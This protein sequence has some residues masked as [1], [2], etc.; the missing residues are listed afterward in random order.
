[1]SSY[2]IRLSGVGGQG[3]IKVSIII[4]EA[5]IRNGLNA[6]MSEIHG[7]AQRGGSVTTEVK[8]GDAFSPLIRRGEA[9]LLI[10]FEPLEVFRNLEIC[11]EKTD[12]VI[13]T[14]K[15]IPF[16]VSIGQAKYPET[17]VFLSS[18]RKS[19]K[20]IYFIDAD[21]IAQEAGNQIYQNMVMLGVA[22]S[23]EGFPLDKASLIDSMRANLPSRFINQN[24]E[25]FEKGFLERQVYS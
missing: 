2:N 4:G 18:I 1:M 14:R 20:A 12:I 17:D 25:A 19:V 6:V 9:D 7:M 22:A 3:I 21:K 11:S 8:I 13:N 16:T 24:I 5:A 10:G 15:I 23:I